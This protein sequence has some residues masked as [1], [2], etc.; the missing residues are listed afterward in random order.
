MTLPAGASGLQ[1]MRVQLL[2]AIHDDW[3][4]VMSE[5]LLATPP[6]AWVLLCPIHE[7][8]VTSRHADPPTQH[9]NIIVIV[10]TN[11]QDVTQFEFKFESGRNPDFNTLVR[12]KP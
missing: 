9:E 12:V 4:L 7:S 2:S 10:N 3:Q 11:L 5:A 1:S 6:Y 8:G